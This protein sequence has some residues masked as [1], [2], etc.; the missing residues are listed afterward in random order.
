[1]IISDTSTDLSRAASLLSFQPEA[2]TWEERAERA[3]LAGEAL[4][5]GR[6]TNT[7]ADLLSILGDDSNWRVR[8]EV[9]QQM[10]W[11]PEDR[12]F[13]LSG[14]LTGDANAYVKRAAERTMDRRRRM[15]KEEAQQRKEA[16]RI[17]KQI[18]KLET[19]LGDSTTKQVVRVLQ[20]HGE[21]I[22]SQVAHDL[23][24]IFTCLKP[25]C[26]DL[27]SNDE[28]LRRRA[29]GRI[30][31]HLMLLQRTIE[32]LDSFTLSP[33][34]E[35]RNERLRDVVKAAIDLAQEGVRKCRLDP[36]VVNVSVHVSE[37]IV[38][39]MARHLILMALANVIKNAF[40]S[41]AA[42]DGALESGMISIVAECDPEAVTLTVSDNGTGMAEEDL[43]SVLA[44]EPGRRNKSKRFS[45]GFGLPIAHR[46]LAAHGATINL[47][48]EDNVGTTV[49]ITLPLTE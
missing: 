5:G 36:D 15:S 18:Q 12:L 21:Q 11:V 17:A 8:H 16:E 49:T 43:R 37:G 48:S 46:N 34:T 1:M 7:A 25:T 47:E 26:L 30:G 38:V 4:A 40:E 10:L 14:R 41:F 45:T 33:A 19:Q 32:D 29:E 23:R 24:S 27:L 20:Q 28:A 39:P 35:R 9:A 44:F 31:D 13:A 6:D 42:T 3:R 2:G 22:L